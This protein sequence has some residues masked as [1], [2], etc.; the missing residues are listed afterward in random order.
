[1]ETTPTDW[2][3]ETLIGIAPLLTGIAFVAYAGIVRLGLAGLWEEIQNLNRAG[4]M[5][6]LERMHAQ[7]DF[8]LWFYLTVTVSSMMLPSA[9]DRRAWL[10]F[11]MIIGGLL[12]LSVLLGAGPWMVH[13]LAPPLNRFVQAVAVVFAISLLVHA[14]LY[15]P[16]R[17]TRSLLSR[18]TGLEVA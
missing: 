11:G 13:H 18:I 2:L 1:M 16:F 9:S 4:L 14:L 17:L 12:F 10:P 8:W 7:P 15:L 6:G 3:R 5:A